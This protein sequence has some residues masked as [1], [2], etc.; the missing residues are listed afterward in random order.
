MNFESAV[1][2]LNANTQASFSEDLSCPQY[3]DP[4]HLYP[5]FD[6]ES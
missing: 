3:R 6:V 2:F 4:R 5:F 1:F